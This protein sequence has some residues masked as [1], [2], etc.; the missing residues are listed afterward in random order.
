M[1][2]PKQPPALPADDD[3]DTETLFDEPMPPPSSGDPVPIEQF[4]ADLVADG[5]LPPTDPE[6]SSPKK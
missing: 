1:K 4:R 6:D 5:I 3:H 2:N